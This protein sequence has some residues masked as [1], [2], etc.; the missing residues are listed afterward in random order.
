M[1]LLRAIDFLMP[2][3]LLRFALPSLGPIDRTLA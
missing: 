3:G 1:A 2:I